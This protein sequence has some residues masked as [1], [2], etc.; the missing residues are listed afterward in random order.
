MYISNYLLYTHKYICLHI[1]MLI[2]LSLNAMIIRYDHLAYSLSWAALYLIIISIITTTNTI[3]DWPYTFLHTNTSFSYVFYTILV[4]ATVIFYTL[5]WFLSL[6]KLY[7]IPSL[8]RF[9]LRTHVGDVGDVAVDDARIPPPVESYS[10]EVVY[11]TYEVYKG[12]NEYRGEVG[13]DTKA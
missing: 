13:E 11:E 8:S 7:Y 2:E 5:A 9:T 1:G 4:I 12:D 3:S 10:G 6:L